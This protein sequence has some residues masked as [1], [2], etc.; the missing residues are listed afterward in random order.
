MTAAAWKARYGVPY[1][2][3]GCMPDPPPPNGKVKTDKGKATTSRSIKTF[4]PSS[5]VPNSMIVSVRRSTPSTSR[6]APTG[7]SLDGDS[8]ISLDI[9]QADTSHPSEHNLSVR[10]APLSTALDRD[11]VGREVEA[12]TRAVLIKKG[13]IDLWRR[14]Q[15]ERMETRTAHREAFTTRQG[16]DGPYYAYWGVSANVPRGYLCFFLE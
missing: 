15:V 2:V 7:S 16:V 3:C 11:L 13:P 1:S 4:F 6:H 9:S 14:M 10:S 5:P 12:K 8:L